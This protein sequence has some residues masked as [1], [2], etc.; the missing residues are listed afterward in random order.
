MN[1]SRREVQQNNCENGKSKGETLRTVTLLRKS[2]R[3][4]RSIA[5]HSTGTTCLHSVTAV[6]ET[7]SKTAHRERTK[8]PSSLPAT[9]RDTSKIRCDWAARYVGADSIEYI[10][11]HDEEWGR[12]V[13]DDSR[14]FE[15]LVLETAQA[16]LSW[17]TILR[18][19]EAYR[20][21]YESF[22]VSAVASFTES[23]IERLMLPSSGIVRNRSKISASV[24]N[25]G[26]VLK[27]REEHGS[28]G[29]FL[30]ETF[31]PGGRPII[32]RWETVA[33]VP[34]R[35]E[36]SEHMSRELKKKGFQFIGP[37]TCYSFMQAAGMVNDHTVSC[38]CHPECTAAGKGLRFP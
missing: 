21:A 1:R 38:F 5:S 3:K 37:T 8:L 33:D 31:L 14:L 30:W 25:A 12:L 22:D 18:K 4:K 15:L 19:R 34:S 35:S 32:N 29:R 17:S 13:L 2:S 36:E 27:L 16:G 10:K 28:F 6:P 23:D 26:L 7:K 20:A 9:S 24:V 11:Y